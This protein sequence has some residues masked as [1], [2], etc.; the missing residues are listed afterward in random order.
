MTDDSKKHTIATLPPPDD[1]EDLYS[2]STKVG[3]APAELLELVRAASGG[4][5]GHA[6]AKRPSPAPARP[7]KPASIPPPARMPADMTPARAPSVRPA[8]APVDTPR[9]PRRSAEPARL[10]AGGWPPAAG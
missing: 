9:S 8:P 4:M 7:A 1:A 2:A 6:D 10:E 3:Q 5:D